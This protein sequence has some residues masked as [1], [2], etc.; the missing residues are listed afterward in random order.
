MTAVA[1]HGLY[2]MILFPHTQAMRPL[3]FLLLTTAL[4][5]A[6][7]CGA[8]NLLPNG[9]F[10]S[11]KRSW[12]LFITETGNRQGISFDTRA[13]AP[14]SGRQAACLTSDTLSR[15]GLRTEVI[16]V[17][18]GQR[19]R[20]SAWLRAGSG[21]QL[22]SKG[23][24]AVI[25]LTLQPTEKAA[26][27]DVHY[28]L[29][30]DSSFGTKP[31]LFNSAAALPS[32][33]TRTEAV[34]EIPH[35][36]HYLGLRLFAWKMSG[37]VC[38]DSVSIE[39]VSTGTELSQITTPQPPQPLLPQV[40]PQRVRTISNL[41]ANAPAHFTPP[42]SDRTFW[43]AQ[44]DLPSAPAL[45]AAAKRHAATPRPELSESLHAQFK[46]SGERRF[47][48]RALRQRY[49]R[50]TQ[51]VFAEGLLN[52]GTYLPFIEADI[53]AL[54]A[55]P[56]WALPAHT[57]D[58][59]S[60]Q[61]ARDFVDLSA[62]THAWTLASIDWLL[63]DRL[64]AETRERIR[65][66]I[67]ERV[68]IPYLQRV[69]S[70][71]RQDFWW[72]TRYHNWNAVCHAGVLGSALL[73]LPDRS[74][75][76]E[77]IA[78]WEAYSPFFLSGFTADGFC[79]EGISYWAYGFGHYVLAAEAVRLASDGALDTLAAP[80]MERIGTFGRD[81]EITDGTYPYFSDV[82]IGNFPPNWLESFGALRYG[83]GGPVYPATFEQR[84]PLSPQQ[85]Y[86]TV[87]DLSQPRGHSAPPAG[88]QAQGTA[89]QAQTISVQMQDGSTPTAIPLA[90]NGT[91]PLRNWFPEGGAL[92]VRQQNP[93]QG[94]AAAFKGGHNAQPH[95]HN[96][97][98][99]FVLVSNGQLVLNE[100]GR[101]DYVRD[102]FGQTRYR[103]GVMNS[104]G[105]PVPLVAGKLQQTGHDARA[106]TVRTEFTD[107]HDLWEIDLTSAYAV[108]ELE[109]LTRTF[110]FSR[111]GAGRLDVVDTV[112]FSSAQDFGNAII[113]LPQ[114]QS[115][116]TG[117]ESFLVQNGGEAVN[118]SVSATGGT[119]AITEQPVM[120]IIPNQP[121]KG[122]RIGIDFTQP[123]REATIR[124]SITPA[125]GTGADL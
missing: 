85:F 20:I 33:W 106:V 69:R 8:R 25:R 109:K 50:L 121:P 80:G 98:G 1:T 14:H 101:D 124:L 58:R 84:G 18:A 46:Q 56:S 95:N 86:S 52:D 89:I 43:D 38:F 100:L 2:T 54:L 123:V 30:P 102:T 45:L 4:L 64:K 31:K 21:I 49:D 92:I 37:Q 10:E 99:S 47:F 55:M 12:S 7:V 93:Q 51:L 111:K 71:D 60:W 40:S 104:F 77:F 57:P 44:R 13:R 76:A 94:L 29:G 114:Q 36:V 32:E 112:R 108:P 65:T 26:E 6:P 96:D 90:S 97:L 27:S 61:D 42:F 110:I 74:D 62:A 35:N 103:S 15:Y 63:A 81:W 17:E 11:G 120:G 115:T 53:D 19:Y 122:T 73:L 16:A 107:E 105:H 41:L 59:K 116:A 48:E 91:R 23:G 119:V 87:F 113:L 24:G 66:E 78:A 79:Q 125:A 68:F 117:A 88:S 82:G 34:I 72:M 75:R 5:L 28:Y 118:V 22:D 39:R 67:N 3:G 9:D 83:S 70:R